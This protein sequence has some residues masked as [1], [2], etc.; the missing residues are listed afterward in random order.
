M[1]ECAGICKQCRIIVATIL[2]E[3]AQWFYP[4][5]PHTPMK[6]DRKETVL[7]RLPGDFAE[8]GG[9][10]FAF[11]QFLGDCIPAS[12]GRSLLEVDDRVG[13]GALFAALESQI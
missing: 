1:V 3:G 7:E 6:V 10:D 5:N 8:L 4:V 9:R 11:E 13:R 2:P 12:I